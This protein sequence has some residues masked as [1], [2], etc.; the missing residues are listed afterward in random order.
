MDAENE[1]TGWMSLAWLFAPPFMAVLP[2]VAVSVLSGGQSVP[3]DPSLWGIT[4]LVFLMLTILYGIFMRRDLVAGF[5]PVNAVAQG[6]LLFTLALHTDTNMLQWAGVTLV[7]CGIAVFIYLYSHSTAHT[8]APRAEAHAPSGYFDLQT[9]PAEL[10][11]PFAVTDSSGDV[12]SVSDTLL[13]MMGRTRD[14]AQGKPLSS[15]IPLDKDGLFVD[16]KPWK[17]IKLPLKYDR[18]YYQL[19]EDR[20]AARSSDDS[21]DPHTGLHGRSYGE[22]N[23]SMELY[24]VRRYKRWLSV[25]LLRMVFRGAAIAKADDIFNAFCRHIDDSVRDIDIVCQVG[26]KDVL[27]IMPETQ[28]E[29]AGLA[30]GKW[31]D[32]ATHL[33]DEALGTTGLMDVKDGLL[34]VN[35]ESAQVDMTFD[36][37][38]EKLGRSVE[39]PEAV[40][41]T[42]NTP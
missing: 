23:L 42:A 40:P 27:I 38:L 35:S 16:G 32:F 34:F 3:L 11:L 20:P 6:L 37:C 26:P 29:G 7:A 14:A 22:K 4:G 30:V 31:I 10:P 24:R 15:L 12:L 5:L 18:E 1:G 41:S 13:N 28:A 19:E 2:L 33:E 8:S 25:A 39:M 17:I 9:N 36:E 21:V